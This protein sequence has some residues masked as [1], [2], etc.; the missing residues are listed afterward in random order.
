MNT[1]FVIDAQENLKIQT[2]GAQGRD[3]NLAS[4]GAQI[5]TASETT[6]SSFEFN[7]LSSGADMLLNHTGT[8]GYFELRGNDPLK[9]TTTT[10]ARDIEIKSASGLTLRSTA[11][12][13]SSSTITSGNVLIRPSNHLN[14]TTGF[15]NVNIQPL[16]S[17][18]FY[19]T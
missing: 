2:S 10:S 11:A 17:V 1:Q 9:I 3:I 16:G 19:P 4:T 6:A 12:D 7:S 8:K 15:G 18:N 13:I 14:M 5:F